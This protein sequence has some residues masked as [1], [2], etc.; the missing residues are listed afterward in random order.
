M[1]FCLVGMWADN[2]TRDFPRNKTV[3]DRSLVLARFLRRIN[4][5]RFPYR[6]NSNNLMTFYFDLFVVVSIDLTI[7][8]TSTH[9]VRTEIFSQIQ[10]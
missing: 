10:L 6:T 4:E 1:G 9:I 3:A 7:I 2:L 5:S 8:Q